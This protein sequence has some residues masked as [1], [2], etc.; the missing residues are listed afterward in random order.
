LCHLEDKNVNK[1]TEFEKAS[2]LVRSM[3]EVEVLKNASFGDSSF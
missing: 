3:K 2:P 1:F